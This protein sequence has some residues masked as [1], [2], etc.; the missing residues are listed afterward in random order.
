MKD[1]VWGLLAF[2]ARVL[3]PAVVGAALLSGCQSLPDANRLIAAAAPYR[4]EIV[5]GNVVTQEQLTQ[6]KIGLSRT[7]IRD[8][9]GS[10]LLTDLFHAD[11]WDYIFTIRRDGT[12]PQRRHIA[13]FFE[14]ETLKRID[15]PDN[16]PTEREF[17]ASIDTFTTAR[18]APALALSEAQI[19]ALPL[20]VKP[21][22]TSAPE[23]TGPV[24]N[25]PPLEAAR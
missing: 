20:P 1:R 15:K 17:V 12:A 5:Q 10:P 7:Q 23:P 11:R 8:I 24:R 16:L 9:L 19:K 6:V 13:L 25:Y 4:V 2:A 21:A 22:L 18:N 3:V 14:G